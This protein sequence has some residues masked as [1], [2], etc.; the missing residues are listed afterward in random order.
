MS[1]LEILT[2]NQ[3]ALRLA[4]AGALLHNLGKIS[5][6]FIE[7]KPGY[8]YQHIV[9]LIDQHCANMPVGLWNGCDHLAESN[10]LQPETREILRDRLFCLPY[11]LDDRSYAPGDLIE[12]LGQGEDWYKPDG[13]GNF[14]ITRIFPNGS[15]LT[16]LLN[17]A[18]R[19]ASG[20]EKQDI[21]TDQQLS[22]SHLRLS[23]PFGWEILIPS[24]PNS[25]LSGIDQ[26]R[27]EIES[28]IQKY[29]TPNTFNEF[30]KTLRPLFSQAIADTRRPLN[31]ITIWDIGHTAMAL[32]IT[33]VVGL[34]L[35]QK[36]ISHQDLAQDE[37]G[38]KLFW[39]VFSVRTAGLSY[40]QTTS[41]ADL[42]VRQGLLRKA[43][44]RIQEF[45][46]SR[47]IGIEVYRDEN[48]SFYLFPNIDENGAVLQ[49]VQ[50]ELD[51]LCEVDGLKL[52]VSLSSQELVSHPKDCGMY[53]GSYI[54][55]QSRQL[56][57][58]RYA[59]A[60]IESAW[61]NRRS[62][63]DI[64]T[65]CGLRPQGYGTADSYYREKAEARNICYV[66]ME[67]RSGIAKQWAVSGLNQQTIWIDEVADTN[68][69]IALLTGSWQL[70]DFTS[71]MIYPR[72][73]KQK[74]EKKEWLLT[75]EFLHLEPDDG[76]EFKLKDESFRWD[77]NRRCLVGDSEVKHPFR[78]KTLSIHAPS[79]VNISLQ[80][81]RKQGD[82]FIL[83]TEEKL[84]F[85]VGAIVKCWGV[86]FK[87]E[88]DNL[89]ATTTEKARDKV[90]TSV[91]WDKNYPFR[92][93]DP[94]EV[95]EEV[96]S[97]SFAEEGVVSQSFARLRRVWDTTRDFWQHVLPT[98]ES[99]DVHQSIVEKERDWVASRLEIK[100]HFKRNL[101]P[102]DYHAYALVLNGNTSLSVVWDPENV[103]FI[104]ADNLI[105]LAQSTQLGQSIQQWLAQRIGTWLRL[106][107]PAGY[108]NNT[109]VWGEVQVTAVQEIPDSHYLPI[110]PILAEPRSF[111]ALV[112]ADRSLDILQQIKLKYEREMGK[113]RNR[114]PLHLGVVYFSRRT[115]LRAVLDAGQT[116][117]KR[118][119]SAQSWCVKTVQQEAP[120]ADK[121]QQAITLTLERNGSTITWS[122]PVV[123]GDGSQDNWYPYVFFQQDKDGNRQ[124]SG[125]QRAFMKDNWL[126]H[127]GDLQ[128]GD[129][130]LFAPSTFDFEF[131][132]TTSRRF[133]IHYDGD[134]RRA[135]RPTRPFYLEDLDRLELLWCLLKQL[136]RTQRY[137][138][139]ATIETTREL[140]N[141]SMLDQPDDAV[142][143]QF[144]SDTLAGA[145]WSRS[146]RWDERGREWVDCK[147]GDPAC[148]WQ[149]VPPD[150][151]QQ[152]IR[153]G[154][155][156]ELADLLELRMEILKEH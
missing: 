155:R 56:P 140:W 70:D 30:T 60:K 152:L 8:L 53:I 40:L 95:K 100:A 37:R 62:V 82:E 148:G 58:V 10:I 93:C 85:N 3:E 90:L 7:K 72:E 9:Q 65:S 83:E 115:P 121:Q 2:D 6:R 125:R 110:I 136:E 118:T 133:A 139:I 36:D 55:D 17:C 119:A 97:Q 57:E 105:F 69:R 4:A 63:R 113:V 87:V 77:G 124:P 35:T 138:V 25:G 73:G 47:L 21:D 134:G 80:D 103:R 76:T 122:V 61:D 102:G 108:G 86:D 26:L 104:T 112:P 16:H 44:D 107:E 74:K 91:L 54:S 49:E 150:Q 146:K 99:R 149:S 50:S 24:S 116:L 130:V 27:N 127:T 123:M 106:E 1:Q 64:C 94:I 5:S 128:A 141:G 89:L 33:Q 131:L 117:L 126:V 31:D 15:R 59:L 39:R 153:A 143:R 20:G 46:E 19:G 23:T 78:V 11:P 137:Q 84:P 135:N 144:V 18:H 14:N 147:K 13:N 66:C 71:A 129:Q 34:I 45:L 38:N 151:Q 132:D 88:G 156:G 75:V 32:L 109:K 120:A 98:N 29:L 142:F 12:Y 79:K 41:I 43:Y 42:R 67:R 48:G 22:T 111:M 145:A 51:S 28:E 101:S 114:L 52:S 81:V 68:G 92:I 96:I 154:V